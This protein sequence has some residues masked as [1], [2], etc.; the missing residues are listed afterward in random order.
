MVTGKTLTAVLGGL[1]LVLASVLMSGA[2]TTHAPALR[3]TGTPWAT[4]LAAADAALRAGDVPAALAAWHTAYGAAL[5]GR[6]WEG[7]ADVGDAYLRI[8]QAHG[9]PAGAVP[10][11]RDLY[12]SALFRARDT[13]SVEG[14]LRIAGAFE[15]LGDRE[16]TVH[17]RRMADRLART[18]LARSGR[19]RDTETAERTIF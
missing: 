4:H 5:A 13:G 11:A 6:R 1:G 7:F 19:D 8:G 10:R 9:A 3:G 17:A 2:R 12:L 14:V 15:R 16:V 18:Q